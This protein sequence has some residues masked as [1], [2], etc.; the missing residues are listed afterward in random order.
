MAKRKRSRH[1]NLNTQNDHA[2]P[3][4]SRKLATGIDDAKAR[5]NARDFCQFIRQ[6][7]Q[8]GNDRNPAQWG[9]VARPAPI[10]VLATRYAEILAISSAAR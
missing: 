8:E 1:A 3:Q 7:C 9:S 5:S 2:V 4:P 6:R 10:D